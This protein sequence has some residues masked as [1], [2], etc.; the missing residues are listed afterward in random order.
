MFDTRPLHTA[1]QQHPFILSLLV[2]ATGFVLTMQNPQAQDATAELVSKVELPTLAQVMEMRPQSPPP[3]VEGDQL[4]SEE[5]EETQALIMLD[6]EAQVTRS[7]SEL[8]ERP[9][10]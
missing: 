10:R 5:A 3:G 8:R 4:M 7:A 9:Q 2:L 1:Q 6:R